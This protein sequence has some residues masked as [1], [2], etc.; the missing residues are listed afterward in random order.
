MTLEKL[1]LA[2]ENRSSVSFEYN[3]PGKANG[4]RIGNPH[5]VFVMIKKDGSRPTKVHIVQTGGVSDSGQAFPSFRMFDLT[6]LSKVKLVENSAP[7]PIHE[8]YNS[9][10]DGYSQTIAK[11]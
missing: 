11:V 10:W 1:K 5:A 9:D 7:F 4:I 6:E 2:I 8:D 3:K